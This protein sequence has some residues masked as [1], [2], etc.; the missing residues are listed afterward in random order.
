M[1]IPL[2]VHAIIKR[3]RDEGRVVL[4]EIESKELLGQSGV[5]VIDTRLAASSSE[6]V[7]IG[8]ELGFPVVL[9]I[10]SPDIVHKSDAGGIRLGLETPDQVGQ[11]YDDILKAAG[12]KH[13]QAII[14]GISVQK[15]ASP[16]VE[17]IIGMSRDAQFGPVLMFGLGGVWVEILQDVSLRV[18]PVT[19]R[20]VREMIKEIK[21]YRML[22]G[23]RGLPPVDEDKL[24]EMLLAVADFVTQYPVVKELDLNPVIAYSDRAVAVDA[25]VVLESD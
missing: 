4:T 13:P 24:E 12:R 2:T 20:D 8:K 19:R 21:G 16:G 15:M 22:T 23:Y 25:R 6:A 1:T 11:A 18:I 3:A 9:K 10:A 17:V 14:Q 7:S 5:N